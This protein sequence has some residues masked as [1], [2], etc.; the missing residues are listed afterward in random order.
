M[1]DRQKIDAMHEGRMWIQ[2]IVVP[3]VTTF[4]LMMTDK[5]IRDHVV[6]VCKNTADRVKVKVKT[7]LGK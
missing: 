4:G 6:A 3:I 2:N 1:T 5:E 7:I